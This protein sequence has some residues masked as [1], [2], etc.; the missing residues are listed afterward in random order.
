[1]STRRRLAVVPTQARRAVLYVRVSSLAGRGGEAFHSPDLQLDAMRA[2]AG[3]NGLLEVEVV[4]DI[5]RTGRDFSRE[6]VRRIME[7]A[8]GGR[9]D[10]LAVYDLSRLGR[11]TGESLRHIAELRDLGVSVVSTVEQIDDSPEGQFM[12]G[13][14][15]GMAQLYS[16]Q[17]GRRWQQV[18]EHRARQGR[19]HGSNPPLGY[20]LQPG[21]GLV[22]DPLLGPL[23][24]EAFSRYAGGHL[25]SHIAR[26]ISD[27]RSAVYATSTLKKALRN[28]VYVGRLLHNGTEYPAQ[29]PALV[30]DLTWQ[31]VQRRLEQ[32]ARTPSRRLAVSHSLVGLVVCDHCGKHLQLHTQ[33]AQAGT[34]PRGGGG[35]ERKP[36]LQCRQRLL[37]GPQVC[38]GPGA[39]PQLEVEAAVLELLPDLIRKLQLDPAARAAKQAAR[40]RAGVDVERLRRE[41]AKTD[42]AIATLAV[43]RAR[44]DISQAA[45]QLAAEELERS[46]A[47][48]R[49]QVDDAAVIADSPSTRATV[50]QARLLLEAWPVM[51]VPERNRGL[52]QILREVR[53]RRAVSYREPLLERVDLVPIS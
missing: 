13:Q 21:V 3:R 52:R 16:D 30:D 22:P 14:F 12:L 35:R 6:G 40:A 23:M 2:L 5:D 31:K 7:L 25:V 1:M 41:L 11:N 48:L 15:L 32:D 43:D 26:D 53:V 49:L 10:V 18:L 34:G 28:P 36:A 4:Q 45:Y 19:W 47:A 33:P 50:K 51:T 38:V 20:Q 39:P 42:K 37:G 8:R 29:H 24:T 44:R 9:F 27:R 17:I 46:A